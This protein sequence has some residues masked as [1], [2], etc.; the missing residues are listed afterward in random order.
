MQKSGEALR[1][2]ILQT[3]LPPEQLAL[4]YLGQE[5][6]LIKSGGVTALIDPYLTDYVDKNISP[7]KQLWQRRYPPPIAPELLDFVDLVLLTHAHADHTDPWTLQ[8]IHQH[9]SALFAGP[10]EVLTL[11]TGMGFGPQRL[12][13]ACCGQQILQHNW[14][15]TPVGVGHQEEHLD[16]QGNYQELSYILRLPNGICLYHGGDLSVTP[17]LL[18]SLNHLQPDI[19][20][21]PINGTGWQ[22]TFADIIGNIDALEA[23]DLAAYM[24]ANLLIPLHFDL[25]GINQENPAR[26]AEYMYNR[27]FGHSYRVLQPGERLLYMR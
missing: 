17:S 10:P 6:I 23:A 15:I 9:P 1:Q 21:L 12:I 7:E 14:Q 4:W 22:R 19:A 11:L 26:L 13:Q 18:K 16:T 8:A 2:Q 20:M 5:G 27:Y 24:E 25:Y 3:N